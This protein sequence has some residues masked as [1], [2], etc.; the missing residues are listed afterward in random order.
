[1]LHVE[2]NMADRVFPRPQSVQWGHW[3]ERGWQHPQSHG[4]PTP[5]PVGNVLIHNRG[6][7]ITQM[8]YNCPRAITHRSAFCQWD[9]GWGHRLQRG[10]EQGGVTAPIPR[11]CWV[12]LFLNQE[13]TTWLTQMPWEGDARGSRSN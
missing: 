10:E 3:E 7:F 2:E 11:Q 6:P 9:V 12:L 1:M 8:G 5:I 13:K 4:T